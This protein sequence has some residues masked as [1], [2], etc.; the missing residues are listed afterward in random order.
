MVPKELDTAPK[1]QQGVFGGHD[2]VM[3]MLSCAS[4]Q[5]NDGYPESP[6]SMAESEFTLHS[7]A[8]SMVIDDVESMSAAVP[9]RQQGGGFSV[10]G[11]H[12]RAVPEVQADVE[13]LLVGSLDS[14]LFCEDDSVFA[15]TCERTF[16]LPFSDVSAVAMSERSTSLD[17]C[18]SGD[19]DGGRRGVD[20]TALQ[21]ALGCP[22][23]PA[24]QPSPTSHL[25]E[26]PFCPLLFQHVAVHNAHAL[27]YLPAE[28]WAGAH[29]HAAASQRMH[30][31][32]VPSRG[33]GG[34]DSDGCQE[35]M[36]QDSLMELG[37]WDRSTMCQ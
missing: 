11:L 29:L 34:G 18:R 21:A 16:S 20:R 28:M 8:N 13:Q 12:E 6:D 17:S 30:P 15:Q 26:H 24:D 27:G 36:L 2:A 23:A 31:K 7:R 9:C 3:A 4:S 25:P 1:P 10:V 37:K 5:S 14:M 35:Y 33:L 19:A 32:A 22:G